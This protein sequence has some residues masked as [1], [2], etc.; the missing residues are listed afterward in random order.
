MQEQKNAFY[1]PQQ[2][3]AYTAGMG[4]WQP[5]LATGFGRCKLQA[6]KAR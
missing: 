5:S 2:S 6:W 4:Q 3:K 1:P